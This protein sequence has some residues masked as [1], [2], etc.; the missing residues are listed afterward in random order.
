MNLEEGG[1]RRKAAVGKASDASLGKGSGGFDA[2]EAKRFL[3]L[4]GKDRSE[5]W[6]RAI[7]PV[8]ARKRSGGADHQGV[9][10]ALIDAK[11]ADGFNLYAITGNAAAIKGTSVKDT[12]I[13]GCPVCHQSQQSTSLEGWAT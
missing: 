11:T 12:D 13:T 5:T 4:L 2:S 9:A 10:S 6:L 3:K 8:K 7:D 1:A